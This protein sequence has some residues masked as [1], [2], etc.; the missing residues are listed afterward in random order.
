MNNLIRFSTRHLFEKND[1]SLKCLLNLISSRSKHEDSNVGIYSIDP[2]CGL[3]DEQKEIYDMASKFAKTKM[4]PFMTEWD[5][6]EI[7][8]IDVLKEAG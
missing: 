6:K 4:K 7:F 8:P 2:A 5:K 1:K 3:N